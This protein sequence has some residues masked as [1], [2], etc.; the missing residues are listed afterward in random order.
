MQKGKQDAHPQDEEGRPN[1]N[2]ANRAHFGNPTFTRGG[3]LEHASTAQ[4]GQ[5]GNETLPGNAAAAAAT[6]T[7][8]TVASSNND[9][10]SYVFIDNGNG[11]VD[12]NNHYDMQPPGRRRPNGST[13]AGS[14]LEEARYSGYAPPVTEQNAPG[15]D[16]GAP[17]IIYAVPVEDDENGASGASSTYSNHALQNAPAMLYDVA[18]HAGSGSAAPQ[19]AEYSHLAPRGGSAVGGERNNMYDLGPQQR[20]GGVGSGGDVAM[21]EEPDAGAFC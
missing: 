21:Y 1:V 6:A 2:A 10:A 13:S 20:N 18:Q 11:M 5:H 17:A 3:N 15:V 7:A 4:H 14:A 16:G 12:E 8:A 9:A 19:S